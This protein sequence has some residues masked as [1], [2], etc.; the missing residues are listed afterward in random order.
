MIKRIETKDGE[1][2]LI[3]PFHLSDFR[4]LKR[5]NLFV[6]EKSRRYYRGL[7][8]PRPPIT[9]P[10]RLII[11]GLIETRFALSSIGFFRWFLAIIPG[12]G[13]LAYVATNSEGDII[14]FKYYN[15]IGR[16]NHKYIVEAA[17]LFRDDYQGKG[18]GMRFTVAGIEMITS[19]VDL[20]LSQAF[21]AN[22]MS[23]RS[24]EKNPYNYKII[25]T[26]LDENGEE[27]NTLIV[28]L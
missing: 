12:W 15:I 23:M 20:V 19:R 4:K 28:R 17:T 7:P 10:R 2:I 14:G 18:L 8:Q 24:V 1:S 13:Y 11:W 22:T 16:R 9:Q 27:V 21:V 5:M 3:R 25:D 6:S 26:R